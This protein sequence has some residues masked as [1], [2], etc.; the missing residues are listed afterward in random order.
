VT[1]RL[2]IV[3]PGELLAILVRAERLY[4]S[5]VLYELSLEERCDALW[6][7]ITG[8]RTG[9]RFPKCGHLVAKHGRL[10]KD[11]RCKADGTVIC[12]T[13]DNAR[14]RADYAK[15]KGQAGA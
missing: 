2:S 11:D 13:C 1:A 14:K 15:K 4:A 5:G 9:E 7:V 12:G 10:L 8:P 3:G 6:M